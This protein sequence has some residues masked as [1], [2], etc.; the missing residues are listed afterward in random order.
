MVS[1]RAARL[2]IPFPILIKERHMAHLL[3]R[4]SEARIDTLFARNL[5]HPDFAAAFLSLAGVRGRIAKVATQYRHP[6]G[7]GSVDLHLTL[8]DGTEILIE[9]KI[10]AGWSV[11]GDSQPVRYSE[12]VQVLRRQGIRAGSL[13]L[14]PQIYLSASRDGTLFDRQ[15][16]YEACLEYLDGDDRACLATAIAQASR[17][18]EP[19]PNQASG[20]FFS[21]FR[22]HVAQHYPQLALKREPNGNGVRPTGSRTFYFEVAH[23]LRLH[24]GLPKPKM[25]LQ[26]WD[27]GAAAPSVKIMLG[28]LAARAHAM[29]VPDRLRAIGGYIRP[30][31]GSLGLVIDTP[32][33][34]TNRPFGAQRAIVDTAL[35][36]ATD[37]KTWWDFNG[38]ILQGQLK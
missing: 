9:N 4:I 20:N 37:L 33:L 5:S 36:K 23:T 17:P 34:D 14:A 6:M 30:A 26:A 21:A 2:N 24:A 3:P 28:G 18:Y 32:R 16:S 1:H 11:A 10:D 31:G 22:V 27:S 15:V 7:R 25:S 19:E 13:L 35:G 38:E 12:S 29:P 8:I